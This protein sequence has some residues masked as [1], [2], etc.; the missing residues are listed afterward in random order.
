MLADE[1]TEKRLITAAHP[2]RLRILDLCAHSDLTVCKLAQILDLP[3]KRVE[4]HVRLLAKADFL[5]CNGQPSAVLISMEE[6]TTAGSFNCW[7][8]SSP[9][10]MD[11]MRWT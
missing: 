1:D 11:I 6:A 8:I 3:R 5:C 9:T 7:S 2:D 10:R 4:R